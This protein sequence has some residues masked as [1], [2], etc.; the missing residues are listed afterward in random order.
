M[1]TSNK[2]EPRWQIMAKYQARNWSPLS[3]VM[4]SIAHKVTI[5]RFHV[6][7]QGDRNYYYYIYIMTMSALVEIIQGIWLINW[8]L[9]LS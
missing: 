3:Y 5:D 7:L 4:D 6:E 9:T 1:S 8:Q 2:K